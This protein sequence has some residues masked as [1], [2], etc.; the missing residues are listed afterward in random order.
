MNLR[1]LHYRILQHIFLLI[2]MGEI[3]DATERKKSQ[4]AMSLGVLEG[5]G[6]AAPAQ[7]LVSSRKP[8]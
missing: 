7:G 4:V 1:T 8:L 2:Q 3:D 5:M 6:P